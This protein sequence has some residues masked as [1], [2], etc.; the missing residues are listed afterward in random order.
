MNKAQQKAY[1]KFERLSKTKISKTLSKDC[2]A[3]SLMIDIKRGRLILNSFYEAITPETC[4]QCHGGCCRNPESYWEEKDILYLT[5]QNSLSKVPEPAAKLTDK[6]GW[7]TEIG[8]TLR[9]ELR[10][11]TCIEYDCHKIISEAAKQLGVDPEIMWQM[12]DE[13]KRNLN[14][15]YNDLLYRNYI[16]LIEEREEQA[17]NHA[18]EML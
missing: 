5:L 14:I 9:R 10:P 6:C 2:E 1:A 18:R 15:K 12:V 16:L 13:V 7:L 4:P 17:M 11:L 3:E 8:C